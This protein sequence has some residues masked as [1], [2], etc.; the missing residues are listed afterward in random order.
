MIDSKILASII[1]V[2]CIGV[3]AAGYQ[4]SQTEAPLWDPSSTQDAQPDDSSQS[5]DD[6]QDDAQTDLDTQQSGSDTNSKTSDSGNGKASSSDN[7]NSGNGNSG[8]NSGT[9]T[10][11]NSNTKKKQ[12]SESGGIS[13]SQAQGIANSH[14]EVE[15][16]H[17]GT[18]KKTTLSGEPV[19]YVPIIKEGKVVGDFYINM[20]GKVIEASGGA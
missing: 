19:Y 16:A 12:N 18:A 15:G 9:N 14:I 11:S 4:M 6:S 3:A 17:A 10:N 20:K 13:S 7:S 5:Q 1:I 2:A 8:S